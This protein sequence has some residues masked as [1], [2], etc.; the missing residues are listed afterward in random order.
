MVFDASSSVPAVVSQRSRVR[1]SMELLLQHSLHVEINQLS[2]GQRMPWDSLA[3]SRAP[4]PT[5]KRKDQCHAHMHDCV[6]G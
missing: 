5:H 4:T 1:H 3:C 6:S 2:C